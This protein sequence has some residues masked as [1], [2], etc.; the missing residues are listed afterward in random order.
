MVRPT[1]PLPLPLEPELTRI[2]AA[3]LAALQLQPVAAVTLTVVASPAA[4][5]LRGAGEMTLVHALV[6]GCVT[7]NP[8]PAIVTSPLRC[9]AVVFAATDSETV[10]GPVPLAPPV[11][12]IHPAPLVA[13]QVQPATAATA[14]LL[15]PPAAGALQDIGDT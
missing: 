14:A 11:T 9:A 8:W 6:P 1:V 10:P 15:V 2:Q 7:V 12:E 5:V 13:V 4:G 3:A